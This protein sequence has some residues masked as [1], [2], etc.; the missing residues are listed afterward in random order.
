M[1]VFNPSKGEMQ[2]SFHS[3]QKTVCQLK[4]VNI[5][6]MISD[7]IKNLIIVL[8]DFSLLASFFLL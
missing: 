8:N 7:Q 4:I 5:S 1:A 2:W 3:Y 6:L